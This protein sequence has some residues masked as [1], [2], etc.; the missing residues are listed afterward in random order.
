[1]NLKAL[2][3]IVSDDIW[4]NFKA[5]FLKK[6]K[7]KF[8]DIF[9]VATKYTAAFLA[10]M[11]IVSFS[12]QFV[13]DKEISCFAEL[14]KE[15]AKAWDNKGPYDDYCWNHETFLVSKGLLP[16]MKGVVGYP[17][18]IN[19]DRYK[20]ETITQRYYNVVWLM[21]I[22]CMCISYS[23]YFL[24]KVSRICLKSGF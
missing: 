20:D 9:L 17:G 18:V 19:Y 5:W 1:M 11:L 22:A 6:H 21:I 15:T 2:T 24:L 7:V 12:N 13:R 10:V 3:N 23:P 4:Q 14:P 16:S 8:D